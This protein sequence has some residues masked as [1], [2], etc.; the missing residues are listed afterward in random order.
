MRGA[1]ESV[2]EFDFPPGL[3]M[4]GEIL[5]GPSAAHRPG[6]ETRCPGT[7]AIKSRD[8][9][10]RLVPMPRACTS[11]SLGWD[12]GIILYIPTSCEGGT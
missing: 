1:C 2:F 7:T 3:D 11:C 12:R 9:P 6:H 4:V 10:G 5:Q 8:V